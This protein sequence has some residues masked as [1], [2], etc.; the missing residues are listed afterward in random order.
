MLVWTIITLGHPAV[1]Q[2]ALSTRASHLKPHEETA[3]SFFETW[4][5]ADICLDTPPEEREVEI[6][7][8]QHL[9]HGEWE[10]WIFSPSPYDPLSPSRIAGERAKGTRFFEDV[11]PPSGW[12]WSSKKWELDL[13]SKDWVAE[14][15]CQGVGV[16][17]E[18]ERWVV[19]L[20]AEEKDQEEEG[21][22][23]VSNKAKL[24]SPDW[25]ESMGMGKTGEWRRRRWVRMVRRK[26]VC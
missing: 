3:K 11:Q 18:G 16:E 17:Q 14:R 10:P 5:A 25:E 22:P 21:T 1:Q 19:D 13:E 26:G 24:K 8:L 2:F 7:E 20:A 23:G 6:F 15:A 9:H 12:E 4:I